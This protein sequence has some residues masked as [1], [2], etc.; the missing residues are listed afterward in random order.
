MGDGV[1]EEVT[2]TATKLPPL[3]LF[4]VLGL[5]LGY[6]LTFALKRV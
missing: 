6:L 3:W 1:I 5:G 2:T 4:L